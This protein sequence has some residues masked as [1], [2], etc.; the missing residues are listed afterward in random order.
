[1]ASGAD[2]VRDQ[3]Q[4]ESAEREMIGWRGLYCDYCKKLLR[5]YVTVDVRSIRLERV[6]W[7]WFEG[8]LEC[9]LKQRK[10][11]RYPMKIGRIKREHQRT[12]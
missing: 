12:K 5:D 7:S 3:W 2:R 10:K 6:L 9:F 8:H 11:Y 4:T 1:M